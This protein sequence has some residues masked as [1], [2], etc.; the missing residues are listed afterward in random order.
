[1]TLDWTGYNTKISIRFP[2]D[3]DVKDSVA[4]YDVPFGAMTRKPY[5][6]VPFE[7]E[8]SA[9]LLDNADYASAKGDWPALNWVDYSDSRGGLAIA[10]SGTPGHQL[11]GGNVLVSLLRS[12]TRCVDGSMVPQPGAYDN[13]VHEFEFA[14]RP[15]APG[16]LSKAI[17][18]G[19]R[20]NRPPTV[21]I[22][23][24]KGKTVKPSSFIRWNA[25]NVVLSSLR[26]SGACCIL[27]LYE[28][29]G[30]STTVEFASDHD[31]FEL[32]ETD[33]E[34]KSDTALLGRTAS[35]RPFEIKTFKIRFIV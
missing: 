19:S 13:G 1:M 34:E 23:D 14:F 2:V 29:L 7:Y 24:V 30:R 35:F 11:V 16:E 26:R 31:G 12:G 28:S 25:D 17:E 8:S 3:L 15:H 33:L 9:G 5:F 21:H 6:E 10:N 18:L 32:M 22:S 4:T 20:L 27:R